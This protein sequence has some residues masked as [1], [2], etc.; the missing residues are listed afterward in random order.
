MSDDYFKRV[1]RRVNSYPRWARMAV[2]L[3]LILGG[4]LGFLPVVGFWMLPLGLLVLSYDLPRV[5]RWRRR[6]EVWWWRRRHGRGRPGPDRA[7][8]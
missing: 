8:D 1:Q 6:L 5:R 7:A 2:G 4:L 3:A